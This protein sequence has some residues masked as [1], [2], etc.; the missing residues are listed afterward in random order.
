MDLAIR[1]PTQGRIH[2]ESRFLFSEPHDPNCRR[3]LERVFQAPEITQVT[4]KSQEG[5]GEVPRAELGFCPKTHSLKE[6]VDRV[7]M[8]LNPGKGRSRRVHDRQN[9]GSNGFA[10]SNAHV[11]GSKGYASL[12][13]HKN[14]V[15]GR[16]GTNGHAANL[17]A[18]SGSSRPG[19]DNPGV[20]ITSITPARDANG[21]IRYFRH[22]AIVT[23]WEIKH[24]LPGR[25]RLK[26]PLL[27][28]K[29]ELCQTIERELTS[30]LGIDYFKTSP[31][32]STVLVQYDRRQLTR[33]QIIE[34]LETALVNA[35][36]PA[37]KDN[38]DLHLPL[39]TALVPLAA[40]AQFAAPAL[41]P[42]SAVLF[43]Y[44]SIPTF[45]GATRRFARREAAGRRRPGRNRRGW[46]PGDDG[47]FP[48]SG[49][50]LVSEL[51]PSLGQEDARQLEEALAERLR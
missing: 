9:S 3:F 16:P 38:V 8:L 35:E 23:H 17:R 37:H 49:A 45:K 18:V 34:I 28:R 33:N 22:G 50:L 47:D 6:V 1:F 15:T 12:N 24:E 29:R 27:H 40:T 7:T 14:G 25:L 31:L 42:A 4:I 46:V 5:S 10:S 41:L 2:L 26:N 44:T 21:E 36:H 20:T 13:G 39:C 43:A 19:V 48:R 32:T 51:R 11:A 30:V